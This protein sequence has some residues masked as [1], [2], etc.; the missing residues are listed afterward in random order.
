VGPSLYPGFYVV[1]IKIHPGPGNEMPIGAGFYAGN[2][3]RKTAPLINP[4]TVVRPS[5]V[6]GRDCAVKDHP[7]LGPN[8][9]APIPAFFR[10]ALA[11]DQAVI[12]ASHAT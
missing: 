8:S 4:S 3:P 11:V 1:R 10:E 6:V 7:R 5:T 2:C 12:D 9:S